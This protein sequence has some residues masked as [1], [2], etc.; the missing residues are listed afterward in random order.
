MRSEAFVWSEAES[1]VGR[2]DDATDYILKPEAHA[3]LLPARAGA[4]HRILETDT[5]V[6]EIMQRYTVR[7]R[8]ADAEQRRHWRAKWWLTRLA[9]GAAVAGI[10]ALSMHLTVGYQTDTQ[11]ALVLVH[12]LLLI[13]VGGIAAWLNRANPRRKWH[14]ARGEAELLR[15]A[16]FDRVL[17][18]R[19]TGPSEPGIA[20][21]PL[22]LAY[23]RR[24]QL[25]VQLS[26]FKT[27][28]RQLARTVGAP[29]WLTWLCF[30]VALAALALAVLSLRELA[31]EHGLALAGL[32][33]LP[34]QWIEQ[35]AYWAF[36]ALVVTV[37]YA[38][39]MS[40]QDITEDQRNA[41]RYL[42]LHANLD[43]IKS[44]GYERVREA[45]E[46]G[47]RDAVERYIGFVH[48]MMLAEQRE[49]LS[50]RNILEGDQRLLAHSAVA[51][52]EQLLVANAST[53]PG[54][55]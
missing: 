25:D 16:L 4:L 19:D 44:H 3:G 12:V 53:Q 43:Y 51:G 15:I 5:G 8:E 41:T 38:L 31:E 27:R 29:A 2:N 22:Q 23:F 42:A 28:G 39:F 36:L 34:P 24:Y 10:L 14:E 45:A 48:Q 35:G 30:L 9:L 54:E 21:L 55:P 52:L 37:L 18:A 49:W 26:Y 13:G 32:P 20:L 11:L 1:A 7:D 17:A 40:R 50:I 33:S 47:N 6:Q 46:A